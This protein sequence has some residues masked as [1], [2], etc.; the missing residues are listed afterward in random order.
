MRWSNCQTHLQNTWYSDCKR[1]QVPLWVG[2]I[3]F[4]NYTRSDA[5]E[6]GDDEDVDG[7]HEEAALNT[8]HELLPGDLQWSWEGGKESKTLN[9]R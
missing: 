5:S 6:D 4:G 1:S 7:E 8:H 9:Y 3:V 2:F